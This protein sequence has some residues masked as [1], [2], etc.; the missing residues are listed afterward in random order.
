MP[1]PGAACRQSGRSRCAVPV[2]PARESRRANPPG[3]GAETLR[4]L[5]CA[6][7]T[8]LSPSP[9]VVIYYYITV[10]HGGAMDIPEKS[11]SGCGKT[12]PLTGFYADRRRLDERKAKCKECSQIAVRRWHAEHPESR[13][14]SRA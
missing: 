8:T 2:S 9:S 11:C 10:Y 4:L 7:D 3:C 6:E 12:F 14:S 13:I 1:L 5:P